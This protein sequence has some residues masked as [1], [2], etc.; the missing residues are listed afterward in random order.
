LAAA[1]R[2]LQ[3]DK[4]AAARD[5]KART[6]TEQNERL[7]AL[8][9]TIKNGPKNVEAGALF[10]PSTCEAPHAT[11]TPG[12]CLHFLLLPPHRLPQG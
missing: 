11:L 10:V 9:R 6:L 8:T 3:S 5:E 7:A 4:E 12:R 1:L 2:G